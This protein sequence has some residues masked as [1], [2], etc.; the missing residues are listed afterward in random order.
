MQQAGIL[1]WLEDLKKGNNLP[2]KYL[3]RPIGDDKN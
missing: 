3:S 1:N 2:K